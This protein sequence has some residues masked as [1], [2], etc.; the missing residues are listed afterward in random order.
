MMATVASEQVRD[1]PR[2]S[3]H[4]GFAELKAGA[5]D[6]AELGDEIRRRKHGTGG[7]D[8]GQLTSCEQD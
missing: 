2:Q 6:H 8:I 1:M 5:D 4:D 7:R 3:G